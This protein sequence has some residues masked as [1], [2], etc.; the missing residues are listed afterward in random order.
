MSLCIRG[1]DEPIIP[2]LNTGRFF[3]RLLTFSGEGEQWLHSPLFRAIHTILRRG[4]PRWV[5]S[6]RAQRGSP[7]RPLHPRYRS[8]VPEEQG[9]TTYF[10]RNPQQKKKAKRTFV[11]SYAD[12]PR[13]ISRT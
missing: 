9:L 3:V 12:Y 2:K 1:Q 13:S 10:S 8:K 4:S 7:R 5:L 6:F 11:G